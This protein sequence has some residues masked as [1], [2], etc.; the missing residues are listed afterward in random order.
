MQRFLQVGKNSRTYYRAVN[1]PNA[2]EDSH[3]DR[4]ERE[5]YTKGNIW[6]DICQSCGPDYPG[7][8]RKKGAEGKSEHFHHGDINTAMSR[9]FLILTD[10]LQ[11]QAELRASEEK[12]GK[13][14][15]HKNT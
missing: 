13:Y 3:Q 15:D 5:E 2:A 10:T 7:R 14:C 4:Q 8:P 11:G 1:L 9:R 6:V 12:V